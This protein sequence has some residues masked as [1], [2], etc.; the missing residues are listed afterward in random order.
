MAISSG[1]KLTTFTA[2][3]PSCHPSTFTAPTFFHRSESALSMA[4]PRP[5]FA[6][7]SSLRKPRSSRTPRTSP[8]SRRHRLHTDGTR[9]TRDRVSTNE[10]TIISNSSGNM[11]TFFDP[12]T[13]TV[14][15][16]LV[17]FHDEYRTGTTHMPTETTT[18]TLMVVL[19]VQKGHCR[20]EM[21]GVR[22]RHA[23]RHM[24]E[25]S[26]WMRSLHTAGRPLES[27]NGCDIAVG[28]A[29]VGRGVAQVQG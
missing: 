3:R 15:I 10:N 26:R 4:T 7:E 12:C 19:Q 20:A 21:R 8:H 5:F 29:P 11:S 16:G 18:G 6:L 24:N 28:V 1:Q 2:S 25:R 23:V 27:R 13:T 17:S 22:S 14:K 9:V